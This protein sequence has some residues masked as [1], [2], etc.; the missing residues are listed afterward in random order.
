MKLKTFIGWGLAISYFLLV[1]VV[2]IFF[3][4]GCFQ[5]VS[6]PSSP[7]AKDLDRFIVDIEMGSHNEV[8]QKSVWDLET[9]YVYIYMFQWTR[10]DG[11]SVCTGSTIAIVDDSGKVVH[12]ETVS[13]LEE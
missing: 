10:M 6:S 5:L 11:R 13:N 8:V 4:A 2:V 3:A 12:Q 7:N 9:N 1:L